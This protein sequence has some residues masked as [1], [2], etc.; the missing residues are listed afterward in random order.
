MPLSLADLA[1]TR[2]SPLTGGQLQLGSA[3]VIA[4]FGLSG[5]LLARSR[6]QLTILPYLRNRALRLVPA[7]WVCIAVTL[8]GVV[9]IAVALGGSAD[10]RQLVEWAFA[11]ATFQIGH[12]PV[13]GLYAGNTLPDWVNGPLWTLPPEVLC[14]LVLAL[15]PGDPFPR[16]PRCILAV[17][18]NALT[19][20]DTHSPPGRVL[21]GG[22]AVCTPR[23]GAG[24]DGPLV[25]PLP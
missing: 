20:G 19:D 10:P 6:E 1:S 4:F 22:R 25:Q 14:Y 16:Q 21:H 7:L 2:S 18:A 9:P 24:V 11:A 3:A 17:A 23:P 13:I 5:Y 8:V 15:M 12:V